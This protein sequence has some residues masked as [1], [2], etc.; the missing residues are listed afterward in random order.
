MN[1][2]I[3]TVMD[4]E[5]G[6]WVQ[7]RHMRDMAR[8]LC[9]GADYPAYEDETDGAINMPQRMRKGK[10]WACQEKDVPAFV[11]QLSQQWVGQE[12]KVFKLTSVQIRIPG[13]LREKQLS[14]DGV[15]PT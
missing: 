2:C 15:L 13:E 3:V 11:E 12:I 5:D 14:K 9:S 1:D 4:T 6:K 10:I 8:M 7:T